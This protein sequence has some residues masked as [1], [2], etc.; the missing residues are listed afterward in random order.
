MDMER[1][2]ELV[3]VVLLFRGRER[4][5]RAEGCPSD[6][7]VSA[8]D[9]RNRAEGRRKYVIIHLVSF[10]STLQKNIRHKLKR[11]YH[12]SKYK[13]THKFVQSSLSDLDDV[14]RKQRKL[15]SGDAYKSCFSSSAQFSQR[16][17]RAPLSVVTVFCLT[18]VSLWEL[19]PQVIVCLT[20]FV[21][22]P[23]PNA[24]CIV[25]AALHFLHTKG[26]GPWEKEDQR[27]A[28]DTVK[29]SWA[30]TAPVTQ[31]G[32][33]DTIGKRGTNTL[34]WQNKRDAIIFQ[35][36]RPLLKL[37]PPPCVSSYLGRLP[38]S[39]TF[40]LLL[41]PRG[42]CGRTTG[43]ALCCEVNAI[44]IHRPQTTE[45]LSA[46]SS[47]RME[48]GSDSLVGWPVGCRTDI[49]WDLVTLDYCVTLKCRRLRM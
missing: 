25:K 9:S 3:R 13:K 44:S 19:Y 2:H 17:S 35:A 15:I 37:L 28:A 48:F 39:R 36:R 8:V 29:H 26:A 43:G 16:D 31:K 45:A 34:A 38:P 7:G 24:A 32:C 10:V 14:W 1:W 12:W 49:R 5:Q 18:E 30:F 20:D 4:L 6:S 42:L 46:Q 33:G 11:T 21:S 27:A 22:G 47:F 40:P 41:L 23:K